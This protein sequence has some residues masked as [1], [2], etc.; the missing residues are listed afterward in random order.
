ME[1]T[2]ALSPRAEVAGA[3]IDGRP[4]SLHVERNDEDQHVT[5]R[6]PISPGRSTL[7]I[8]LQNDFG[9]GISSNLPPLGERSQGLRVLSESWGTKHESLTVE[10]AGIPG[11]QYDFILRDAN[12][13]AS[14]EGAKLITDGEKRMRMQL[15]GTG[16]SYVHGK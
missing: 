11:K 4:S 2:P 14:L 10:V 9:Y 6:F 3:E 5:L 1:F 15:P 13:I 12:Q 7:R 8:R 16:S